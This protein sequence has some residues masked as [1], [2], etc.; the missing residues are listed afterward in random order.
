MQIVVVFDDHAGTQLCGW[1]RH[2][3]NSPSGT[4][5][6]RVIAPEAAE[7]CGELYILAGASPQAPIRVAHGFSGIRVFTSFQIPP[8][9]PD[10][11][12]HH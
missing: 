2:A 6:M 3:K 12:I 11:N 10:S 4:G 1:N 9:L 5:E 8:I 7:M